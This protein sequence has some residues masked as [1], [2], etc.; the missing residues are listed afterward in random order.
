M[1]IAQEDHYRQN[2]GDQEESAEKGE[3]ETG[4]DYDYGS[5]EEVR[6]EDD[7]GAGENGDDDD[8]DE[9][10]DSGLPQALPVAEEGDEDDGAP[11]MTG[12]EY[13]RMV[14]RESRQIPDVVRAHIN[15]RAYDHLRTRGYVPEMARVVAPPPHARPSPA[16]VTEL[17]ADFSELRAALDKL[18]AGTAAAT[19]FPSA[20]VML[21]PV[22]D[23]ASWRSLCLGQLAHGGPARDTCQGHGA[24]GPH[25][26][27]CL[28]PH[29]P[30]GA[31]AD[32]GNASP[33][34]MGIVL[35]L[36]ELSCNALFQHHVKWFR[37][38]TPRSLQALPQLARWI[39]ALSARLSKPLQP[40][41]A[42]S[43]RDL[44]R[45]ASVLR[46]DESLAASDALLLAHLNV[47]I[48]IAGRY[49]QQEDP[50]E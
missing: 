38:L 40:E 43:C 14:R 16:W 47:I 13:L 6:G 46:A 5:Q 28:L 50:D 11:P 32:A 41:V 2:Y 12:E 22:S 39:Y 7:E 48:T 25:A 18:G 27:S 10:S 21:P 26:A 45:H 20:R 30:V 29:P 36:D 1:Q 8:D 9:F 49:F 42:A 37:G 3:E 19:P 24:D 4:Y 31:V 33:P 35:R 44:L 15:P 17:L 23:A 34:L